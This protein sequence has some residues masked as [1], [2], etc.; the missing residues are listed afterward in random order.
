MDHLSLVDASLHVHLRAISMKATRSFTHG[1]IVYDQS[2]HTLAFGKLPALACPPNFRPCEEEPVDFKLIGADGTLRKQTRSGVF[3]ANAKMPGILRVAGAAKS[4]KNFSSEDGW[5]VLVY[6]LKAYITHPGVETDGCIPEWLCQSILRQR[7][8]WNKMVEHCDAARAKCCPIPEGAVLNLVQNT[9]LPE[10]DALNL[11]LGRVRSKDKM[12][13]PA[14]LKKDNPAIQNVWSFLGL[15]RHRVEENLPVPS[16]LI[17]KVA[18]F[19]EPYKT[20]FTPY[21]TFEQNLILLA[22]EEAE[23][24]QLRFYELRPVLSSFRA[25]LATRKKKHLSWSDGWPQIKDGRNSK[26]N[27]WGLSY[28]LNRSGM[29]ANRLVTGPGVPGLT[30]GPK[31]DPALTGH[32]ELRGRGAKRSL[33]AAEISLKGDDGT[34][35][36]FRFAVLQWRDFPEPSH[37]KEWKLVSNNGDLTLALTLEL[38]NPIPVPSEKAAG[39]DI[40]WRTTDDGIRFGTLYE[41]ETKSF[42]EL[43]INLLK[44]PTDHK[45]RT[46][47]RIDFGSTR[48]DRRHI[49]DLLPDWQPGDSIPNALEVKEIL[50]SRRDA[51]KDALKRHLREHLGDLTPEWITQAGRNGLFKICA[52]FKDDARVQELLTKWRKK[53]QAIGDVALTYTAGLVRR[54]EYGQAQVAHDVCDYLL[55]KGITR[56]IVEDTFLAKVSSEPRTEASPERLKRSQRYRQFTA[57]ARFV[58]LLKHVGIK[59]GIVVETLAAVNTTRMCRY[60]DTLNPATAADKLVCEKCLRVLQQDEN[61]AVNLSRFASNP[62]LAAMARERP[63]KVA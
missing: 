15:L 2:S 34:R 26:D 44:S 11:S 45:D 31:L 29:E 14:K 36:T 5:G 32:P 1:T 27:R 55:K 6:K 47:F 39:L 46:P 22:E 3:K 17:E 13:H 21:Y 63:K 59:K 35:W 40:G 9:I 4:P 42:R 62:E 23:K 48:K 41:P 20:D 24:L 38:Q 50:Q 18:S 54:L 53:D 60:C 51:A 10:I 56:L 57:P 49:T 33:R 30:F 28:Y 8:F 61:A 43:T 52:L 58:A 19:V 12:K 25:A 7:Q 16:G 37:I